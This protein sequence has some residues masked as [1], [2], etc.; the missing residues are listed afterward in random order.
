MSDAPSKYRLGPLASGLFQLKS[1]K[2]VHVFSYQL[3]MTHALM[4]GA[5]MK[6]RINAASRAAH[7]MTLNA[8][9]ATFT[10]SG[11]GRL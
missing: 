6:S 5:A 8:A 10:Q 4:C 3:A 7:P 1:E 9:L 2:I 11:R